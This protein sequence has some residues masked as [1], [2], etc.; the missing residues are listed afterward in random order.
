[1]ARSK[2][3]KKKASRYPKTKDFFIR[4]VAVFVAYS[5]NAIAAGALLGIEVVKSIMIAGIMGVATTLQNVAR[6]F[7]DDAKMT[8]RE[9]EDAFSRTVERLDNQ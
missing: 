4:L 6:A 2:R 7:I 8:E 9:L 5:F 1:M 3:R